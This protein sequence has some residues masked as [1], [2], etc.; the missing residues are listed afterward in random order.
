MEH[1]ISLAFVNLRA[2]AQR[3]G[4]EV[5]INNLINGLKEYYDITYIG[6]PS[7]VNYKKVVFPFTPLLRL[8]PIKKGFGR[9]LKVSIFRYLFLR[10]IKLNCDIIVVNGK[11]DYTF[12]LRNKKTIRFNKVLVIKHGKFVSPYPDIIIN[13]KD[14]RIVV[15]NSNE[16]NKLEHKYKKENLRLIRTGTKYNKKS[17]EVI[18]V[19]AK[20]SI[21]HDAYI[22]LS[23]GRL[24]EKQKRFSLGI[25]TIKYALQK[26]KKIFYI[27]VGN[28]PNKPKYNKMIKKLNLTN[29]IKLLGNISEED[30]N[31]LLSI[32]NL[33][34]IT[35]L[36]ETLG[37]TM[38]EAF[39]MGVPVLTTKTDGSTD[40]IEEGYNGFYTTGEAKNIADKIL[41]IS[42]LPKEKTKE[43]VENA[44]KTAE[45]YSYDKMIESYKK[46]INEL[47]NDDYNSKG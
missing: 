25:Q 21:P 20:F 31:G 38:V 8:V 17:T 22:I 43:I 35:S 1:K 6:H 24:E 44:H 37:L 32:S 11:S 4:Q 40:A 34:L 46:V 29:N 18:D 7:D 10:E 12:L 23:I 42:N 13:D 41:E 27:I 30:K 5:T 36:W 47:I 26:N 14:Y 2:K 39:R 33:L 28:G 16:L 3:G 9:L 45:L 15:L 19:R